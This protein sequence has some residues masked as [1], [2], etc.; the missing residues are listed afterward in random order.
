MLSSASGSST[1]GQ[2]RRIT[3]PVY[4]SISLHASAGERSKLAGDSDYMA[5][6]P[7]KVYLVGAG[8]GDPGLLT[9]RGREVLERAEAVFYDYLANPLLLEHATDEA[10]L[11]CLGQHGKG[12]VLA[13]EEINRQVIAAAQDGKQVVRLKGGDPSVFA[14][15]GEEIT[16]L[17]AAGIAYEV[18][19]GVTAALAASAYAGVPLTHR[20][21]ASCVALI[22]GQ[23]CRD[24]TGSA[25]DLAGLAS[26]PG[27]LV[28]Y[29]GV[30]TAPTWAAE[31][32]KH[33]KPAATPVAIV[34]H[35][36]L[37]EQRTIETTLGEVPEVL[38]PRNLRPPA[39][40]VVG[41][42]VAA[43]T[44]SEWF[45]SR[46]LFG[47]TVLVTRPEEQAKSLVR[48]LQQ[49][50][51]TTKLQPAIEITPVADWSAVDTAIENLA[52]CDWLVFS[53]AN[54][55]RF[56][57]NRILQLDYDLRS[58]AHC[59]LAAIGPATAE[60]LAEYHLR[61]DLQPETYRAEALAEQ[62]APQA[63]G[64]RCL[65]LR[66]S[67]GRE[68]LAETLSAASADVEQLVVYES[69]DVAQPRPEVAEALAAGHFDWLTVTSSAIARSLVNMFGDDLRNTKLAAI[70]PLS[71][72]VLEAAGYPPTVVAEEYT[73]EGLVRGI[74][75]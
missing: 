9:L 54:G 14:R 22:T 49:L 3:L 36:S 18:V 61:V 1:G 35:C 48:K 70:S 69:R 12:R 19:P 32:M 59:R 39:I 37:A 16:A 29:M 20:D 42:A 33:G 30:T 73:T 63:A 53:S 64:Q 60:T 17:E 45:T 34:R 40:I 13:Q 10:E 31:L 44:A 47:Q 15:T 7:G 67:R 50:G 8:P 26:F 11:V 41:E 23:E 27:T 56:F 5:K 21:Y 62:L 66:A 74:V 71:A 43:R 58:L 25:L 65:L 2:L 72:G 46:P 28:F 57:L 24:K 51:A 75:G 68:V 6:H 38:A 55:V 4:S 52:T